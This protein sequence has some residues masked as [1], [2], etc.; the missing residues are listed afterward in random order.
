MKNWLL[1]GCFVF[2]LVWMSLFVISLPDQVPR[3]PGGE[4]LGPLQSPSNAADILELFPTDL[5]V[6]IGLMLLVGILLNIVRPALPER[7][8]VVPDWSFDGL[9][10]SLV[11]L[12]AAMGAGYSTSKLLAHALADPFY[13]HWISS[14][15]LQLG[16][17]GSVVFLIIGFGEPLRTDPVFRVRAWMKALTHGAIEYV[18]IYPVLFL[19]LILNQLLITKLDYS[20]APASYRFILTA[21]TVPKFLLLFVL[22]CLLAPLAEEFFFR[23]ILYRSLRKILHRRAAAAVGAII[24]SLVHFELQFFLPLVVL[25]YLLCVIYEKSGS[26]KVV[27]TMHFLQNTISLLIFHRLL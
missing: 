11:W 12:L 7:T 27:I 25:G 1:A 5:L 8:F 22:T 13:F 4:S 24:F 15:V 6:A 2:A 26:I 21:D 10:G 14:F 20:T 9:V 19:T 16:L 23:G 3:L 17:L 18:R